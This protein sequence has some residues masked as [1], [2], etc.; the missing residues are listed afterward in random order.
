MDFILNGKNVKGTNGKF[1]DSLELTKNYL[2]FEL[3]RK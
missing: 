1:C 2:Y 3:K